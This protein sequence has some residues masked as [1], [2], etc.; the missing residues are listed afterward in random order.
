MKI[1]IVTLCNHTYSHTLLTSLVS[2]MNSNTLVRAQLLTGP[3]KCKSVMFFN[4]W[5]L[6]LKI[7][8]FDVA[9]FLS[10][11]CPVNAFFFFRWYFESPL[12][13]LLRKHFSL[14][15][16]LLLWLRM[17]FFPV[18]KAIIVKETNFFNTIMQ[19][20]NLNYPW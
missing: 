14:L 19:V 4:L 18:S 2:K 16:P 5:A 8:I 15:K 20:I 10:S 17:F 3:V 6:F 12:I 9:F 11:T 1:Q 13:M 7:Y